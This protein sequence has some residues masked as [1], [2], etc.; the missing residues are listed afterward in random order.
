M[1][2]I[3]EEL[4]KSALYLTRDYTMA[5]IAQKLDVRQ[6]ELRAAIIKHQAGDWKDPTPEPER[7][8]VQPKPK[9]RKK[10]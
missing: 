9:G 10:N 7:V 3:T 8:P 1:K 5:E 6:E 4:I 2:T